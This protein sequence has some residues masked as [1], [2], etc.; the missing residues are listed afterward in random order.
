MWVTRVKIMFQAFLVALL[1]QPRPDI[2]ERGL[3]PGPY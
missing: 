2:G 1:G 3:S